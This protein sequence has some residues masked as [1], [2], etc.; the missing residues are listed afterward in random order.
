MT[1]T[2][3]RWYKREPRA[4]LDGVQGMG[5]EM[6]GAYAVLLDLIYARG[7]E[8]RRDDRHLS[9][10][11]GCSVRKATALTDALLEAGKLTFH[12]GFITNSRA[13]RE[14]KTSRNLSEARANAGRKGGEKSGEARRNNDL[15]EANASSKTSLDKRK[16]REEKKENKKEGSACADRGPP[17]RFAEFW[18]SWP[19]KVGKAAAEKAWRKLGPEDRQAA[20]ERVSSWWSAW[21]KAHPDASGIHPATYL[22]GRR[23]EDGGSDPPKQNADSAAFWAESIKQGRYV[24]ANIIPAGVLEEI[25]ARRLCTEDQIRKRGLA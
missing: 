2:G 5:P 24:T 12:D 15:A 3:L 11:L 19:N 10:I 6:I 16:R 14:A 23:W 17:D 20:A 25:R 21:R 13:K 7:G 1:A 8:T 4:F 9:G 22:N 18:I